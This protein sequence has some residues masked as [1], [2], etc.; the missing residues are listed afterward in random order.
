M[1]NRQSRRATSQV[2][3][4]YKA[5]IYNQNMT[6][7]IESWD[8]DTIP[9]P[10]EYA[11]ICSKLSPREIV[12]IT[13]SIL[14]TQLADLVS[15]ALTQDT[16]EI[17]SFIGLNGDGRAPIGTFGARIQAAYLLGLIDIFHL[18]ALRSLK[19]IRNLFSHN[20]MVSMSDARIVSRIMD[21][22]NFSRQYRSPWT[23]QKAL[24]QHNRRLND[25]PCDE[26]AMVGHV[27]GLGI[28]SMHYISA[29]ISLTSAKL[30][31]RPKKKRRKPKN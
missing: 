28:G 24:D 4:P 2:A 21:I 22:L 13:C 8:A 3:N 1:D 16:R 18:K 19:D 12:I 20:V 27:M 5:D 23:S 9:F 11:A 17:E 10:D 7:K 26:G 31:A 30:S 15:T 25:L 6:R 14:D 29:Q